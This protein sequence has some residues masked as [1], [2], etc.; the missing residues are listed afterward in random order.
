MCVLSANATSQ[1]SLVLQNLWI[2]YH[3]LTQLAVT[4]A[5]SLHCFSLSTL[6]LFWF[7]WFLESFGLSF[8]KEGIT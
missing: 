3:A 1:S 8:C 4:T 6:Q 5:K 2:L 7:H